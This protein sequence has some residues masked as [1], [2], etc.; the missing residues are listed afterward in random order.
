V[1]TCFN[2]MLHWRG[3]R[4][5]PDWETTALSALRMFEHGL[6]LLG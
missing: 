3:K 1:I 6:E 2:L 5:D 4:H